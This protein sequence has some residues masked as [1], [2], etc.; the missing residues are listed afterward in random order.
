MRRSALLSLVACMAIASSTAR[1]RAQ[2]A[3]VSPTPAKAT[4]RGTKTAVAPTPAQL[5]MIRRGNALQVQGKLDDAMALYQTVLADSPDCVA[6]I[7]EVANVYLA[8]NDFAKT[9]EVATQGLAYQGNSVAGLYITL[10]SAYDDMGN[11]EKA[12]EAY[13]AGIA[14]DPNG[15]LFFNLALT[16]QRQGDDAAALDNLQRAALLTPNHARTS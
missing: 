3:Q 1:L 12:I 5:D 16:L 11:A 10:G 6:A 9:V 13:R 2:T 14:A 8:K 15:L 4:E 7:E